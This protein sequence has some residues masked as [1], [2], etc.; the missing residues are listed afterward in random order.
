MYLQVEGIRPRVPETVARVL[1]SSDLTSDHRTKLGFGKPPEA[2]F[3]MPLRVVALRPVPLSPTAVLTY[4]PW[5]FY[6]VVKMHSGQ[7]LC[8]PWLCSPTSLTSSIE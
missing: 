1:P 4:L 8:P 6:I 7:C 3:S 5:I 2:S